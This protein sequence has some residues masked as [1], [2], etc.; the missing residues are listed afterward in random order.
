MTHEDEQ[1]RFFERLAAR[2]DGRFL[3]ARWPR[4]QELKAI[5]I[6]DAL[7]DVF[8][9]GPVAEIGC[10]TAQ[11]AER[12]LELN[13]QFDYTGLDL[14]PSMLGIARRRLERFHG[15]VELRAVEGAL[16][17]EHGR[18]A[19]AYGVDVLHHM[20]DPVRVLRELREALR[21]GAPVV[22]LEA[23]P[24]F[25]ITTMIGLLQKEERNVLKIGFRNL[26]SWFDS[27]A[28]HR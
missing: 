23:N 3:R 5:V 22:F 16:C 24:R 6:E 7:E 27:A 12:L 1:R 17:L 15:R 13:P 8:A 9:L 19:A 14:S 2:Y 20:A 10:G 18:Y 25:P 4:N 28:H 26:R 21:P 11:I